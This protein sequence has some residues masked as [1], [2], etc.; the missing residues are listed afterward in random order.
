MGGVVIFGNAP[1]DRRPPFGGLV[2]LGGSPQDR[3][4]QRVRECAPDDKLRD[5][6]HI[7]AGINGAA[8]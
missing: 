7:V 4:S 2:V 5:V 3:L 6:H 8:R 1:H